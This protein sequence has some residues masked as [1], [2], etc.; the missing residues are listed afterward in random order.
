M[1][2]LLPTAAVCLGVAALAFASGERYA[3]VGIAGA[4]DLPTMP[5]AQDM[6]FID[7]GTY[8]VPDGYH[9]VL[10]AVHNR[11]LSSSSSTAFFYTGAATGGDFDLFIRVGPQEVREIPLGYSLPP[12]TA[13]VIAWDTT[14]PPPPSQSVVA[15]GYLELDH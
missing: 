12:G 3:R 15:W 4:A 14:S 6:V 13:L 1:K 2:N 7:Q 9:F 8:T 11:D 5:R 10:T